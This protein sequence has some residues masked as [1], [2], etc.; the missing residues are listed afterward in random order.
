MLLIVAVIGAAVFI[1][2]NPG[3]QSEIAEFF[4]GL[5]E[6]GTTPSPPT[7]PQ[8]A[9]APEPTETPAP[10]TTTPAPPFEWATVVTPEN[11][12]LMSGDAPASGYNAGWFGALSQDEFS[13]DDR[14]YKVLEILYRESEGQVSVRLDSCLPP[15]ALYALNVG[16]A[17]L[18]WPVPEH[19]DAECRTNMSSQQ[20]FR[21]T[22]DEHAVIA[23]EPV[24]V[25]LILVSEG[26]AAT[27]AQ[28]S[29]TPQPT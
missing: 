25:T 22:A 3:V 7:P 2:I 16:P 27:T 18:R 14:T 29:P 13:Y 9:A 26:L 28:P 1:A 4:E 23:D 5:G 15:A 6:Q 11:R 20:A 8:A 24:T 17:E 10:P 12:V 21:F 19:S